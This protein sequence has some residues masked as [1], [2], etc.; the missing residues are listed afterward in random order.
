MEWIE[1]TYSYF[2]AYI[3]DGVLNITQCSYA[4]YESYMNKVK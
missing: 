1:Y 2:I 4:T 3:F